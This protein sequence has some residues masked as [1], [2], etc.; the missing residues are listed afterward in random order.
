MIVRKQKVT[1]Q[2]LVMK[3]NNK[4]EL[5][6]KKNTKSKICKYFG[7]TPNEV[8]S[9]S[10]SNTPKCRL[11]LKDVSARWSNISNLLNHLKL[12]HISEYREI[13]HEKSSTVSS[14][15]DKFK[16]DGQQTLE[17]CV[18]K[19]S[20]FSSNCK[21][22]QRF[23]EA[24][25]NCIVHDVMPMY[26]IDKPGFCAMVEAPN[27]RYQLPHKDYFNRI[28]IPSMY[29]KTR[30]QISL[31]VRKE[32]HFFSATT[33]FWSSCTSDLY[34]CLTVRYIHMEWNLQSHFLQANYIPQ[35]HTGEQLQDALS[36]SFDEW[37]LDP[38]KLGAITTDSGSN[39]KLACQ[40]LKWK[41]LSCFGHNLDLAI[42]KGL[43][44]NQI[45]RALILCRKVVA[46]FSYSWKRQRD[47]KEI[48][49]Q[50]DLPLKKLKGDV[51]TR[52]GS[53]TDMIERIIEQQDTIHV[54]LGQDQKV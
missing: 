33:D 20:K 53:K 21:E 3:Q 25:T 24:V 15:K 27:P 4:L 41:H 51:C 18:E 49:Q 39:I 22:H 43:Q 2:V 8:G 46:S 13:L 28:A 34:L 44:D 7:Y 45:N 50:K 31:K 1:T 32:I 6:A 9:P 23:T 52:L 10:D 54:M 26:T 40:L 42:N 14:M 35:D 11:C 29:E 12:H 16:T 19:I 47:L 5:V 30:E 17:Q 38:N 48:Q 37:T 36:A